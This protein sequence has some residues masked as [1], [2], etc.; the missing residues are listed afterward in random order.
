MSSN[1]FESVAAKLV[2]FDFSIIPGSE[3]RNPAHPLAPI[4]EAGGLVFPY[5]P[6]IA[7]SVKIDYD[8][9]DLVHSNESYY[10]Y[11]STQNRRITISNAVFTCDTP[12]NAQYTLAVLH[13]LWIYSLMDSG[14]RQ[15]GR[16]PSPMWFSA[17]G[18]YAFNN[19]PVLIEGCDIEWPDNKEVD[20]V[21]VANPGFSQPFSP[22]P[23]Q[24]ATQPLADLNTPE[25]QDTIAQT[26][27][28]VDQATQDLAVLQQQGGDPNAI[29][30]QQNLLASLSSQLGQMTSAVDQN[31]A[32]WN[33][34]RAFGGGTLAGDYTWLPVKLTVSNI[35]LIVQ[36]SPKFWKNFNLADYRSGWLSSRDGSSD[37]AFSGIGGTFNNQFNSLGSPASGTGDGGPAGQLLT[38]DALPGTPTAIAQAQLGSRLAQQAPAGAT[39]TADPSFTLWTNPDMTTTSANTD[40]L[41]NIGSGAAGL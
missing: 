1:F 6:T 34:F 36:H 11:K 39:S 28:Q 21:P 17:Y 24:P 20:Y 41:L 5:T 14:R 22:L 12:E 18:N 37:A 16:P 30:A 40:A 25:N 33:A 29:A 7:E 31:A 23:P 3:W 19:V 13:F 15:T 9:Y 35:S 2:P 27:A 10:A 4:F 26:S 32:Q 8:R 38:A